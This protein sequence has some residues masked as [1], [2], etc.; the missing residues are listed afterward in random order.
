MKRLKSTVTYNVPSWNY[1]NSDNLVGGDLTK[2]KCRF[3]VKDHNGYEC[4]LHGASLTV[5]DEFIC[6]ADTC[7]RATAGDRATVISDN[8]APQPQLPTVQPKELIKQT[9]ELYITTMNGLL[10]DGY[11]R[12]LAENLAKQFI[13][14]GR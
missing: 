12:P 3:C 14:G 10:N 11:P 1:C 13:L 9:I 7:K 6:K 4:L 2:E 5:R 8:V